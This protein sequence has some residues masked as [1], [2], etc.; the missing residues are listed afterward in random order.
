[1]HVYIYIYIHR[2][3]T[4]HTTYSTTLPWPCRTFRW[5]FDLQVPASTDFVEAGDSTS[6]TLVM[7]L[8][9]GNLT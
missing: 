4:L 8:P 7:V 5:I 6:K 1:M 3:H 2:I 9:S